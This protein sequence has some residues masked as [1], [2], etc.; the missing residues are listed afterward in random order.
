M[1]WLLFLLTIY[2]PI[3][4]VLFLT[5][6]F[7]GKGVLPTGAHLVLEEFSRHGAFVTFH[8]KSILYSPDS[9][10][11][12]N[13]IIAPT[14]YGYH[15]VDRPLSLTYLDTISMNNIVNWIKNGGFFIAGGNIGRN[16]LYGKDRILSGNIL[17]AE[18]WPLGRAFGF[19][20]VEIDI[21]GFKLKKMK[22]KP[23]LFDWYDDPVRPVEKTDDW[24]LVPVH[25]RKD[26]KNLMVWTDGNKVYG[27]VTLRKYGDGYAMLLTS[28]LLLHPS[29]DGGWADVPQITR[30]YHNLVMFSMGIKKYPTGVDPWPDGKKAVL[31]VTLDD[32]G[33]MS[34]YQLTLNSLLE[35]VPSLTF[36]VTGKLDTKILNFIKRFKQV[37]IGNHSFN[38][39]FFRDLNLNQSIAEIEMTEK[40]IG[41]SRVFRFPY[42]N[43]TPQGLYALWTHGFKYESSIRVDHLNTFKGAIF[44]YNLVFSFGNDLITTDLIEMS[45]IKSD[46]FFYQ[47]IYADNYPVKEKIASMKAYKSYLETMWSIIKDARGMMVQM[48]H[49]MYEGYNKNFLKP[50]LDFLDEVRADKEVWMTNLGGIYDWWKKVRNV[51]VEVEEQKNEIRYKMV[52]FNRS[53][54]KGFSVWIKVT[55]PG[56]KPKL[57]FSKCRGYYTLEHSNNGERIHVIMA[58]P[59]GPSAVTIKF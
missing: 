43:Y 11:K 58:I 38:H 7:D 21:K 17:T 57:K 4:R 3:P 49:P 36:F 20:M 35:R 9:L 44:P 23:D 8:D 29:F 15:D 51:R 5:S 30:F 39:P 31:A 59:P 6:S 28:F 13:I 22:S 41:K 46:W 25:E 56:V 24:L 18:E 10:K 45:P 19:D 12:F 37:E 16:T 53:E 52:N 34:M 1:L 48:G 27:G 50:L 2:K 26:V 55:Q 47:K 32:G 33:K 54:L 14:S 40:A 42:V